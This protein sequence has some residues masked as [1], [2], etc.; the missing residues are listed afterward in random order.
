MEKLY[1]YLAS[2]SKQKG[3]LIITHLQ[4]NKKISSPLKDLKTLNLPPS[5]H[6]DIQLILDRYKMDYEPWLDSAGDFKELTSKLR[7]RGFR[8]ISNSYV[9]LYR[10]T[11]ALSQCPTANL[12]QLEVRK[13][14]MRKKDYS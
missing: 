10:E 8:N 3:I 9:P 11:K 1:L 6:R 5:W 7:R 14:M 13:T 2:R 4:G 12:N